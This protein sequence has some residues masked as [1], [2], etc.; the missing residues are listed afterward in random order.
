MSRHWV[1]SSTGL[2][3]LAQH[4]QELSCSHTKDTGPVNAVAN[5][6]VIS[7]Y[8]LKFCV[9]IASF[10]S[11]LGTPC[12]FWVTSF[13]S[14]LY[15]HLLTPLA[16]SHNFSFLNIFYKYLVLRQCSSCFLCYLPNYMGSVFWD[17]WHSVCL[18]WQMPSEPFCLLQWKHHCLKF[19][20]WTGC[21]FSTHCLFQDILWLIALFVASL[22]W[23]STFAS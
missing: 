7:P 19:F 22:S 20:L 17:L 18:W 9:F 10:L 6:D 14:P 13:R 1:R 23:R 15:S 8:P 16:C 4:W 3:W 11:L 5:S 12:P 2:L 21:T